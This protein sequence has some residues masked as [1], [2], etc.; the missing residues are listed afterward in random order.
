MI[1]YTGIDSN[2]TTTRKH[3]SKCV[4]ERLRRE[5]E[6]HNSSRYDKAGYSTK[7]ALVRPKDPLDVASTKTRDTLRCDDGVTD[8]YDSAQGSCLRSSV[9]ECLA[10]YIPTKTGDSLTFRFILCDNGTPGDV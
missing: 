6:K 9:V 3:H 5:Y 1:S 4:S 2:N 10:K 8:I 7:N